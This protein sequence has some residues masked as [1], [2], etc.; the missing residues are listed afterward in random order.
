MQGFL[1][2]TEPNN[3]NGTG[4]KVPAYSNFIFFSLVHNF[5]IHDGERTRLYAEKKKKKLDGFYDTLLL[6]K[7]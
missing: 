3:C 5:A 7:I 1:A 2:P 4:E 6:G